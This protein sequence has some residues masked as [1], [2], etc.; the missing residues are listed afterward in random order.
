M[1]NQ[2]G[3]VN[4]ADDPTRADDTTAEPDIFPLRSRR[5]PYDPGSGQIAHDFGLIEILI[6]IGTRKMHC[7]TH[8]LHNFRRLAIRR[9]RHPENFLGFPQLGCLRILLR[10]L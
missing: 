5:L 6:L 8:A 9:E 1:P 10:H 2:S 3:H 7:L 4:E